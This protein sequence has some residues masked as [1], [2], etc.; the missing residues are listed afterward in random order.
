MVTLHLIRHGQTNWNAE[1]RIQGQSESQLDDIGRAQAER[2]REHIETL[3]LTAAYSSP[4][5]RTTQTA[6]ILLRHQSMPVTYLDG[7]REVA[8]GH[9][10]RQL[11]D[12]IEDADQEQAFN[13]R[14][15]PH[16]FSLPGAETM[17]ELQQRG[18]A[19]IEHIIESE[20]TGNVLVVS[21]GGVLK[22]LMTHYTGVPL[23]QMWDA[24]G[25]GN[26][27]HSVLEAGANGHRRLTL[28]ADVSAEQTI[29]G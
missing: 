7:L 9:W 13:F 16:E 24:P 28:I 1:R 29:W 15:R 23:A 26:C 22:A 19:A 8:L 20:A 3:G 12:E 6:E 27:C 14:H 5:E 10:E 17:L 21:H 25:L 11:W 4:S 2:R 18:V